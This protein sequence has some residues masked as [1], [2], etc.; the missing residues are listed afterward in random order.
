M[1]EHESRILT[2]IDE[3]ADELLQLAGDMI[4]IPSENPD[5]DCTDVANFTH[6]WLHAHGLPVE[7]LDAGDGRVNV[8]S[9]RADLPSGGRDLVLT[10]HYD[11]VPVGDRSRWSFDPFAGDVVD[12]CL[13]G[14]G[15]S[16]MKAGLAGALFAHTLLH[17]LDTPLGG[18]LRFLGVA[19][20]ETGGR[21]G[22]DW[23]LENGH[24]DGVTAGVIAE[25]A[26]RAHPTIG[27]KGSNWFRLTIDGRPGHG[28]LQP[29]HGTNANL[30][31]ARA[32]LAL[33]QLWDMEPHP[34]AELDQLIAFSK[35]YA[36]QREGYGPGIGE[37]FSHVTINV[38]RVEG[39]TSTNVVADRAVVEFDTRVPIG[40]TRSEVNT[41]VVEILAEEGIEATVTPLGFC[42]EP[43]WT[44]PDEPI[45]TD[46]VGSLRDLGQREAAGVLQ[47]A[48][49]D[50]R[51]FRSHGIPVLQYGPAELSTIHGFDERAPVADVVL[52]A[53]TYALTAI[54]HLGLRGS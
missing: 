6:D 19:D 27:Q 21:R 32:T 9:R 54:R 51:T 39:G 23:V 18:G 53:K 26:E 3:R 49:S 30:V 40:L 31:A 42:S 12:G 11:V 46:L 41:R 37:V 34:P 35:A 36:E 15:A 33:Q 8:L 16:D 14:R 25:P 29:L 52:A 48:S 38:G 1:P 13:R 20:E 43:N 4:K 44:A 45:V 5:G 24:L 22:A 17:E 7:R 2:A 10:G 50:A 28:S 47:W